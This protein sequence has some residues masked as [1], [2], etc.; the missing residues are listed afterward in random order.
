MLWCLYTVSLKIC[1]KS[2]QEF[3]LDG[4]SSA[5]GS[6]DHVFL[7]L[8]L[9]N[10]RNISNGH[11]R[12]GLVP[13]SVVLVS[14]GS[15]SHPWMGDLVDTRQFDNPW[16]FFFKKHGLKSAFGMQNISETKVSISYVTSVCSIGCCPDDET[17]REWYCWV[18]TL[19]VWVRSCVFGMGRS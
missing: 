12:Y 19:L 9:G 2:S 17:L 4:L 8:G 1:L 15:L 10:I 18:S 13:A 7:V 6:A 11:S 3:S 16:Y 14:L 5:L